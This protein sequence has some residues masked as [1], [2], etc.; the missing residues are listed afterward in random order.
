[1][2]DALQ[3]VTEVDATIQDVVSSLIQSYLQQEA[4]L[5][6]TVQDWSAMAKPGLDTIKIP[7]AP[8]FTVGDKAENTPVDAQ[9]LTYSTD[10]LAMDKHKAIQFLAEDIAQIQA[11][12]PMMQDVA[13]RMAK[14]LAYQVDS[15]IYACLKACS[16]AA[17]D[18]LIKYLD[19]VN[20]DLEVQDL[21]EWRRLLN[22][23][24]VP[25]D[26]RYVLI[27][28]SKEAD[29]LKI[30][31]FIK[32]NEYGSREALLNGEIGRVFGFTVI[33]SN[34][35]ESD[36]ACVAYHRSHVAFAFQRAVRFE[37]DRDMA[38]LATRLGADTIYG[39]KVLDSGKRGVFADET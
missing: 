29:M 3:G 34:V 27:P 18:H 30:D 25:M 38:N 5:V 11:N 16:A 36:A 6:P 19:T 15:D 35:S 13:M 39:C 12:I 22:I 17:P 2:A 9:T 37:T 14:D 7:R 28:P 31:N 10:D 20:N 33:V 1:M 21:V 24:N 32:A 4:L 23:Q 26:D 8:G